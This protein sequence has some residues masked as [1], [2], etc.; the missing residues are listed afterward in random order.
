MSPLR[1]GPLTLR[2][3][4]LFWVPMNLTFTWVIPPLEPKKCEKKSL[5]LTS[6]SNQF[7]DGGVGDFC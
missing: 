6:A 4:V 5:K 3:R 1:T 2:T 7:L